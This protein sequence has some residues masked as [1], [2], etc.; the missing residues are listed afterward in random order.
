MRFPEFSGEWETFQLTDLA[1][2]SKERVK[3][4]TLSTYNYVST[5]N[6]QQDFAGIKEAI[7]LPSSGTAVEFQVGDILISNIRPYLRK[8]WLADR[9]GGC[10]TDV[11]SLR[12]KNEKVDSAFLYCCLANDG[13]ISYV[14]SGAKG[15]KMPRGD[16]QHISS[17]SLGV[18]TIKEQKKISDLISLLE[19]RISTQIKIIKE[20]KTLRSALSES[21]Y[22]E[23]DSFQELSFNDVGECYSGLSGKSG[24]DF[25]SGYPYIPYTNIFA[26]DV[27]D[28]NQFE[29]VQVREDESQNIVHYGDLLMTLS[30][31]TP[32]EVG[33]GSVYLGNKSH[34]YLNSFAFGIHITRTDLVYPP[35]LSWLVSTKSFRKFI[36][37]FAQGS[38]RYNLQ[39]TDFMKAKYRFPTLERQKIISKILSSYSLKIAN[40]EKNLDQYQIQKQVLLEQMFI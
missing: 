11:L 12:T 28:E 31:E 36:L 10:S 27:I 25:G 19:T 13:F 5:E 16:K 37:P 14:M 30:S 21:L 38:T 29:Y 6:M 33:I 34:L 23:C 15:V 1:S 24:E 2:F 32:E 9:N 7:S 39:K 8:I 22:C 20:L 18:P 4:E 26:N 17:F 3:I 35:Y 40:E